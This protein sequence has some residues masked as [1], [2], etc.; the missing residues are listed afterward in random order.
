MVQFRGTE[1]T[2]T[3][4]ETT[5]IVCFW[6]CHSFTGKPCVLPCGK[7]ENAY[8]VYGNFCS[9]ECAA[10]Y[11][12]SEKLGSYERWER[13]AL[14]N[15]FY[16]RKQDNPLERIRR[17]PD[18]QTLAM[19]GGSRTIEQFRACVTQHHQMLEVLMPPLVSVTPMMDAKPVDFYDPTF[20]HTSAAI[21]HAHQEMNKPTEAAA[22]EEQPYRLF[23]PKPHKNFENS[24]DACLRMN[25]GSG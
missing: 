21:H 10:A 14:L 3:L 17:A 24:I 19:F 25:S 6:D 8:E 12:F 22:G 5:T 23:R 11:L 20:R 18:R 4:P 15:M 7:R 9:P 1:V 2:L 13:Y 16:R